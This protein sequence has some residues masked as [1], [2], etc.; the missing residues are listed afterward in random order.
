V[1]TPPS[2]N[3]K[4]EVLAWHMIILRTM[5]QMQLN[6]FGGKGRNFADNRNS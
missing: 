3:G 1:A 6:K 4:N 5:L 2:M